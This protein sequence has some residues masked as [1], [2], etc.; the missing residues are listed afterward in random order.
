[1]LVQCAWCLRLEGPDGSFRSRPLRARLLTDAAGGMVSHGI[2][3][4]CM[5]HE[6]AR[7]RMARVDGRSAPGVTA[8]S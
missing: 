4:R 6:L 5:E 7:V 2:C 1:M 8:W 3:P